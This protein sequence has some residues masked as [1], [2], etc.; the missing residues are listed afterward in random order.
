MEAEERSVLL[1]EDDAMVESW[2]RMSLKDSVFKLAE[3]AI[4]ADDAMHALN[5]RTF[6]IVLVD[7]HLPNKSGGELVREMRANGKLVPVVLMTAN[8]HRGF[9]EVAREVGAQGSVLK[10]GSVDDLL[11]ALRR[12]LCGERITDVRHP[13]RPDGQAALSRREREVIRL[14]AKGSTNREIAAELG[15]ADETVKTL[16]ARVF[17]KLGTRRRAEAVAAAHERGV[18]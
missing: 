18:L 6:D 10:T 1:V 16:V 17:A 2:L 7:F 15:I 14:V 4:S 11:S 8:A 5:A 12:V 13:R 3:V 9:N